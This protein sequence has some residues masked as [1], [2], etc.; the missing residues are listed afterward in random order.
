MYLWHFLTTHLAFPL[1]NALTDFHDAHPVTLI[2][3]W[4]LMQKRT[5]DEQAM[6]APGIKLDNAWVTGSLM[7]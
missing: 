3:A 1:C 4:G 7:V 5:Q 6:G 2:E